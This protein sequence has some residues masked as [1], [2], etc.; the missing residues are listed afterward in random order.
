MSNIK[1]LNSIDLSSF[2]TIM[3]GINVLISVLISLFVVIVFAITSPAI[4][5]V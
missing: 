3:T 4:I 5:I 2:T 1:V